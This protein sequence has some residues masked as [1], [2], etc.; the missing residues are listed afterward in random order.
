MSEAIK[1][2]D[3]TEMAGDEISGEQLQRMLD[4][5][6]WASQYCD[7]KDV[8]EVACG[9]GQGLGYL[10]RHAKSVIGGDISDDVLAPARAYYG[11]DIKI[12]TIDAMS[13]PYADNSAD[14]VLMFE[15]LYYVPDAAKFFEEAARILRP[16]GHLLI[17]SAN[18]DL[19]DFNPS[20]YSHVYYSLQMLNDALPK[21]GFEIVETAGGTPLDKVSLKQ[22]ILRPVKR[23]VV[24]LG[25][26]PKTMAGKKLLKRLVFGEMVK[27][28]VELTPDMGTAVKPDPVPA[29]KPCMTY[30]VIYAAARLKG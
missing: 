2:T 22:K 17:V 9:S 30:K 1:F 10:A 21:Y 14:T 3:V 8:V 23:V 5:Y 27:M 25:L 6:D 16:G 29:D 7:G 19:Y 24:S 28:P 13:L 11:S 4:R 15:A 12:D 20:P 26:M 18:R